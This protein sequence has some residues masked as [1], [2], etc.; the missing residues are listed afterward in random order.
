MNTPE[1]GAFEPGAVF[2][3]NETHG[4]N[5]GGWVGAFVLATE[6]RSWGIQGFVHD[7]ETNQQHTCAYIRLKWSE[8]DYIGHAVLVP[9]PDKES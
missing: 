9:A 6:I 4:P 7:I 1:P 2:Q 5:R 8:I 3:I